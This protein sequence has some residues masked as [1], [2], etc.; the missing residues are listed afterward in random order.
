MVYSSPAPG[1][2]LHMHIAAAYVT[3]EKPAPT[4]LWSVPVSVLHAQWSEL[5]SYMHVSLHR[6][7][8][9]KSREH[10]YLILPCNLWASTMPGY[11]E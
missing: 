10:A 1:Y 4:L 9:H 2:S 11:V 5:S 3:L 6:F 8:V 7:Y